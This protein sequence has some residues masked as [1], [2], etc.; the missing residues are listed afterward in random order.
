MAGTHYHV[1]RPKNNNRKNDG[2][3]C[4]MTLFAA[5]SFATIVL[6]HI[7]ILTGDNRDVG[8]YSDL[9][10]K[11]IEDQVEEL[12]HAS[13]AQRRKIQNL[14]SL[15][16]RDLSPIQDN[17]VDLQS[18]LEASPIKEYRDGMQSRLKLVEKDLHVKTNLTI[19]NT[20]VFW[21]LRRQAHRMKLK[22]EESTSQADFLRSEIS[23]LKLDLSLAQMDRIGITISEIV[24]DANGEA[25]LN[26]LKSYNGTFCLPWSVNSDDWWTHHVD[27]FVSKENETDYCFSPMQGFMKRNMFHYLYDIQFRGDCTQVHTKRMWSNGWGADVS[28]LVDGLRYAMETNQPFQISNH[29]WHY[30]AKKDG[31]RPVCPKKTMA[32]YFLPLSRCPPIQDKMFRGAYYY[33]FQ[34]RFKLL[35]NRY[36]LEYI[37]R[38]RTWL[39]KEVFD[40][41]NKINLSTPCTVL[42]VRRGDVVLHGKWARRYYAIEEY[43]QATENVTNITETIFLITDDENGVLEARAKFPKFNWVVIER[44]RFKG[45]EGGWE[46]HFPSD[47]SKMEVIVLMSIFRKATECRV[48]THTRSNLADYIAALMMSARGRDFVRVDMNAD[49]GSSIYDIKHSESYNISRPWHEHYESTS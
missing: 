24:P 48:L 14:R 36:Y 18:R 4:Y 33:E 31:S 39:R 6:C 34:P 8:D 20:E 22:Q 43:I 35:E 2:I 13:E 5:L 29:V 37:T 17:K 16:D 41:S 45:K 46:N 32:C 49:D 47:D 27:W 12:L 26:P 15:L 44:P 40:F 19:E 11:R 3:V 38:P 42:H 7:F 23:Q 28:N 21:R 25:Y 1:I 9:K 30:S 10:L